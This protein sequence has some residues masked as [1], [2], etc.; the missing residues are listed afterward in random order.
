MELSELSSRQIKQC[1]TM[2]KILCDR[3]SMIINQLCETERDVLVMTSILMNMSTQ[4]M[5]GIAGDEYTEDMLQCNIDDMSIIKGS[6]WRGQQG[7]K[8]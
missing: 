2:N 1:K 8:K 7:A 4:I 5:R 6:R 3:V